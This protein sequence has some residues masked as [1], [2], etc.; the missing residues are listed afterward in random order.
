MDIQLLESLYKID[1]S[2]S[3]ITCDNV[4]AALLNR[5]ELKN[6]SNPLECLLIVDDYLSD[7]LFPN[8]PY[9]RQLALMEILISIIKEQL[10]YHRRSMEIPCQPPDMT[11]RQAFVAIKRGIRTGNSQLICWTWIYYGYIRVD[12]NISQQMFANR[13]R[14]ADRTIRRYQHTAFSTIT[15]VLI[16]KEAAARRSLIKAPE[17]LIKRAFTNEEIT[18]K[19]NPYTILEILRTDQSLRHAFMELFKAIR[20]DENVVLGIRTTSS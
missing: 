18:I 20:M 13:T 17:A 2:Y 8:S 3:D 12:L 14:L 4:K 19:L 16:H 5:L 1:N 10:I 6:Q 9:S 15:N 7:E 11:R